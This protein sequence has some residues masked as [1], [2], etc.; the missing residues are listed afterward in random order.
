MEIIVHES[1][2]GLIGEFNNVQNDPDVREYWGTAT[3]KIIEITK[4]EVHQAKIARLNYLEILVKKN[5]LNP[6][7]VQLSHEFKRRRPFPGQFDIDEVSIIMGDGRIVDRPA[8][9]DIVQT[10]RLLGKD[11]KFRFRFPLKKL[12]DQQPKDWYY[13][14]CKK[15]ES[16]SL[17]LFYN[18]LN[19]GGVTTAG[20]PPSH[21]VKIPGGQQQAE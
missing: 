16:V 13:T 10:A 8:F 17:L 5:I 15:G 19:V 2:T 1:E 7:T 21:G 6:E 9:T 18:T 12:L 11:T 4:E 3:K 20:P 14:L